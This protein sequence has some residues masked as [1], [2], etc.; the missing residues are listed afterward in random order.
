ML[1]F[2]TNTYQAVVIT[3]GASTHTLYTY[4]CKELEWSTI[5]SES[6][7]VGYNA[8]GDYFDNHR[9]SGY[10][11]VGNDVACVIEAETASSRNQALTTTQ[12]TTLG[13]NQALVTSAQDCQKELD[14]DV[15]LIGDKYKQFSIDAGP[16]PCT[17]SQATKD[18]AYIKD[19]T[20]NC[21]AQKLQDGGTSALGKLQYTR[22]CCYD[23]SG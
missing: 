9:S 2:Q 1:C 21:W 12:T 4:T 23:G 18:A 19:T 3:D 6:A 17:S 5:G 16:C 13:A 22:Q 11:T 7:V 15:Q 8:G 10:Y 14:Q 20:S